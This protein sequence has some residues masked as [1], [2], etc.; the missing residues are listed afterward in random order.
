MKESAASVGLPS[1]SSNHGTER[2][3]FTPEAFA[4]IWT[5]TA[6]LSAYFSSRRLRVLSQE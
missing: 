4:Q 5:M 3:F 6:D 1:D 2:T